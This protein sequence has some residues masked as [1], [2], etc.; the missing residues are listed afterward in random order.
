MVVWWHHHQQHM[1]TAKHGAWLGA[2]EPEVECMNIPAC[3]GG[4]K[5][6]E[7][8]MPILRAWKNSNGLRRFF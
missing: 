3:L 5:K 8:K 4:E 6:E 2:H 7:G 1:P